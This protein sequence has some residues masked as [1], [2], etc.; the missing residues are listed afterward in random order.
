[1]TIKIIGDSIKLSQFLKKIN[2]TDTGG[3]AK[4]FIET[5]DIKINNKKPEGRSS[6]IHPGDVVWINDQIYVIE[7]EK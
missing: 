6:K 7:K 4:F 5:N 3:Q 2:E 1:M